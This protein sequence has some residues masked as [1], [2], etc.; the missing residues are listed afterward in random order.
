MTVAE[1]STTAAKKEAEE[2][3]ATAIRTYSLHL[4]LSMG[5][6]QLTLARNIV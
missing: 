6:V 1:T 2:E 3:A 5:H 4:H